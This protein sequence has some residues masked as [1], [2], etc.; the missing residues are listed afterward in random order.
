MLYES[1]VMPSQPQKTMALDLSSLTP[2]QYGEPIN[3]HVVYGPVEPQPD[4]E[5]MQRLI[6]TPSKEADILAG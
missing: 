1:L 3:A 5:A 2:T 6:S 4:Y